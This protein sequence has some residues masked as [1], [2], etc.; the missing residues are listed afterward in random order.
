[1]NRVS[2]LLLVSA[3]LMVIRPAAF[4]QDIVKQV[5]GRDISIESRESRDKMDGIQVAMNAGIPGG[6]LP[7]AVP[8]PNVHPSA[9]RILPTAVPVPGSLTLPAPVNSSRPAQGSTKDAA[10]SPAKNGSLTTA[11]PAAR[12]G[13]KGNAAKAALTPAQREQAAKDAAA[14]AAALKAKKEAARATRIISSASANKKK[15]SDEKWVAL[16]FDDGPSPE[17][18]PQILALLKEHGIHATFCL[19]GRQVK[20]HPELVQQIVAEGHKI[21]DHSMNHDLGLAHRSDKKIKNEILGEKTLIQSVV[22]DAK[23]EYFRAPGGIW[24]YRERK[25]VASWGMKSLGWSVDS[26]D[27]EEPGV[28]QIIANVNAQL[29]AGGVVLM[30]DAGGNR[31]QTVAALK[32]LIPSLEKDGYQ[33]GFPD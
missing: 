13:Q 8:I 12:P 22:P 30:H 3:I 32:R 24:N 14:K 17:F 19:L 21:A 18:T 26:R 16:T 25:L 31:S 2:A 33:F 15:D 9:V 29:K 20:K 5:G 10:V 27:W 11:K 6:P 1:M 7:V 4:S 23:I 28:D